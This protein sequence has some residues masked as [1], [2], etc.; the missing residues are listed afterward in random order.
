MALLP[1]VSAQI[2]QYMDVE[3][4]S[5][6]LSAAAAREK[7]RQRQLIERQ[8]AEAHQKELDEREAILKAEREALQLKEQEQL[9]Q[10]EA[11]RIAREREEQDK[12]AGEEGDQQQKQE[13]DSTVT[14][15]APPAL[16]E[17][18]DGY[19]V[20]RE[21]AT[22]AELEQKQGEVLAQ[23]SVPNVTSTT[24]NAPGDAVIE[25]TIESDHKEHADTQLSKSW[26]QVVVDSKGEAGSE[27]GSGGTRTIQDRT[28]QS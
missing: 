17:A 12:Q 24:V 19:Q 9:D 13:P 1:T 14:L 10:E 2:L 6:Q 16:N 20:D 25:E 11:A 15:K 23:D 21:Q 26:A 18:T 28:D 22:V 8:E 7:A 3:D 5:A 4:C 27:V